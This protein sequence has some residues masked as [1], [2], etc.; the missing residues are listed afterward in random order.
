MER[1]EQIHKIPTPPSSRPSSL[2]RPRTRFVAKLVNQDVHQAGNLVID[3]NIQKPEL[4]EDETNL[5][6]YK[7][8]PAIGSSDCLQNN[9]ADGCNK[10][11]K[12]PPARDSKSRC[13]SRG[14]SGGLDKNL[15]DVNQGNLQDFTGCEDFIKTPSSHCNVDEKQLQIAVRLPDGSRHESC[16]KSSNTLLDVHRYF[17]DSSLNDSLNDET[18]PRNCEFVSSEVP[19]H[20]FSDFEVTL[21]EA[22]I[23]TRTL[24]YLREVD[25]D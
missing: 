12:K 23:K 2:R 16:F 8:L 9:F 6:K 22:G 18:I 13:S 5:Q 10:M 3:K 1:T 7:I 24:L 14:I 20:V 4:N 11:S 19:R 17:M 21:H 25:P 15:F